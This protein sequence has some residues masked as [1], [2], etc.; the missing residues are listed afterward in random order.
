MPCGNNRDRLWK[1]WELLEMVTYFDCI[2][3][4]L[5]IG[6]FGYW[7]VSLVGWAIYKLFKIANL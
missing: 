7:L 5:V 1:G 4:G 2:C 3:F 6:F